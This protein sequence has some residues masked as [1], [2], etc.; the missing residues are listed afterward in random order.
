LRHLFQILYVAL[1]KLL[2]LL[3]AEVILYSC[4]C[5][6]C[7]MYSLWSSTVCLFACQWSFV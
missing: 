7:L 1:T 5:C 3:S 2:H 6:E 4:I